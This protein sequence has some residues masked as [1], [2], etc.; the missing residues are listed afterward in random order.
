MLSIKLSWTIIHTD[1]N[2][3]AQ[4]A[5]L[6]SKKGYEVVRGHLRAPSRR[7]IQRGFSWLS[8]LPGIIK[9]IKSLIEFLQQQGDWESWYNLI[10]IAFDEMKVDILAELDQRL[11]CLSGPSDYAFLLTIRGLVADWQ[12]PY[13]TAMDYTL[14]K[15]S[16]QQIISDL[17]TIKLI[18]LLSV[19]DMGM[20]TYS[21]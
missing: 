15:E 20:F 8:I 3:S 17:Y 5:G 1:F 19:C 11:E 4:I 21:T 12:F 10:S 7:T 18:V 14:T 16:Y 6:V 13:F 2:N 9:P